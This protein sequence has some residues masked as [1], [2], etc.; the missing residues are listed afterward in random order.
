MIQRLIARDINRPRGN[1]QA[2]KSLSIFN[3]EIEC[4]ITRKMMGLEAQD[5]PGQ[6]AR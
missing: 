1:N 5:K 6:L 4:A 3:P 2:L